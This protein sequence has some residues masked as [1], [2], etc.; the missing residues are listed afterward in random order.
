MGAE[1]EEPMFGIVFVNL[2]YRHIWVLVGIYRYCFMGVI[3]V[4]TWLLTLRLPSRAN[5]G[6]ALLATALPLISRSGLALHRFPD[7]LS[8]NM[9]RFM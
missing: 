3:G 6:P 7:Q 1:C 4:T 9:S 2:A 8:V 5:H